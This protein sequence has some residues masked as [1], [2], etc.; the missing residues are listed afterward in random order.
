[1]EF[2]ELM[3]AKGGGRVPLEAFFDAPRRAGAK[4]GLI[5]NFEKIT[6]APNSLLSHCLLLLAPEPDREALLEA[7]YAAYFE[8][9]QDIGS[10]E[11]LVE[12]ASNHGLDPER[13]RNALKD[14]A[15]RE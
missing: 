6:R 9:G 1:M 5:F 15:G 11:V 10:L 12:V 8:D 13:V 3:Q 4:V 14:Q 2:R 7:I